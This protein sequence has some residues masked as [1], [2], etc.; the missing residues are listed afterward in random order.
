[1]ERGLGFGRLI[2]QTANKLTHL[3]SRE[4]NNLGEGLLAVAAFI[5][6]CSTAG[7]G[8][9]GGYVALGTAALTAVAGAAVRLR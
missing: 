8:N 3:S 9:L 1:M 6:V 5:L 7:F 4:K 2:E